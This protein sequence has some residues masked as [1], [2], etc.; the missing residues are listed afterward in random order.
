[1]YAGL[2]AEELAASQGTASIGFPND[3]GPAPNCAAMDGPCPG[4]AVHAGIDP[5]HMGGPAIMA[6]MDGLV[7]RALPWVWRWTPWRA[8]ASCT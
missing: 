7:S 4:G 5:A 3:D 1:M 2:S 6:I 8:G